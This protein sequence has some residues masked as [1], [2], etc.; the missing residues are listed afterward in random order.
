MTTKAKR[1]SIPLGDRTLDGFQLP[2]GSYRMSQTQA[3][4]CIDKPEINARRFLGSKGI[5]ALLGNGYTPDTLEVES[6]NQIRGQSR[7]NALPLNVVTAYWVWECSK[8]NKTAMTLMTN[9]VGIRE[10]LKCV[11]APTLTRLHRRGL[12]VSGL[13]R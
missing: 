11:P 6:S 2:D 3:A 13:R 8:G 4:E 10:E 7:I 9:T 12:N 1:A 5:K